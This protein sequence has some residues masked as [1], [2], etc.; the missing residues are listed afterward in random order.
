[1][2]VLLIKYL[3][4]ETDNLSSSFFNLNFGQK[5]TWVSCP[6]DQIFMTLS[7]LGLQNNFLSGQYSLIF[8]LNE[9]YFG[10]YKE[11]DRL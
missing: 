11:F 7:S 3:I 2:Y 5:Y 6:P 8:V 1:M 4:R 9:F 10:K